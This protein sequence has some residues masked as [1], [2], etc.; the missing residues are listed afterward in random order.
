MH[1]Q[2]ANELDSTNPRYWSQLA[3]VYQRRR[4]LEAAREACTKALG[5][6]ANLSEANLQMA[7]ILRLEG[8]YEQ[9]LGFAQ[10][11]FQGYE[12]EPA[13]YQ[14][15]GMI[16]RHLGRYQEALAD[17]NKAVELVPKSSWIYRGRARIYVNLGRFDEALADYAKAIERAPENL[18]QLNN[19]AYD[20][21]R[22]RG[23][24]PHM[25]EHPIA[26]LRR[27]IEH[28][29]ECAPFWQNL[30]LAYYRAG[31]W[32]E[33][34]AALEKS[35]EMNP[36][37]FNYF[38]LAMAHWQRGN[39]S[40]AKLWYDNSVE[41][42]EKNRLND[43]PDLIRFRAEAEELMGI[44]QKKQHKSQASSQGSDALEFPATSKTADAREP[45]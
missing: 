43:E 9:A 37:R 7:G 18:I 20:M 11:G 4:N 44:E 32:G 31:D 21:V 17:F 22:D 39:Q 45:R 13:A 1:A 25:L 41:W 10:K 12:P 16:Y 3:Y 26:W 27:A 40:E 33:A 14:T 35:L 19:T 34:I 8:D 36:D 5:L 15:R 23:W 38:F 24:E 30:G 2:K 29:P 28:D 6:N 42:M